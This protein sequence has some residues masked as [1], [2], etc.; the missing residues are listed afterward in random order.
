[1]RVV[2]LASALLIRIPLAAQA[3]HAPVPDPLEDMVGTWQTDTVAGTAVHF[4]CERSPEGRAL[5]C[6]ETISR[7]GGVEHAI[8]VYAADSLPDRYVYFEVSGSGAPVPPMRV[9]IADHVWMFGGDHVAGDGSYHRT[10][11]D[12]SAADGTFSWRKESSRDGMHWT[13]DR[14]GMVHRRRPLVPAAEL[15]D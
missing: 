7:R 5:I 4:A 10:L 3:V 1:M 8:G 9:V 6:D 2:L 11:H 14:R 12:Y 13:V 15:R